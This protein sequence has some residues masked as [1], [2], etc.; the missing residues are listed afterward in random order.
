LYTREVGLRPLKG[1]RMGIPFVVTGIVMLV[2]LP[3]IRII[4]PAHRGL[5]EP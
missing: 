3:G 5:V 1:Y 4:R 2:I